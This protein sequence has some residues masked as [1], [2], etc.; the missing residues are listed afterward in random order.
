MK[1]LTKKSKGYLELHVEHINTWKV[2]C[3]YNAL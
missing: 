1:S 2:C 3:R